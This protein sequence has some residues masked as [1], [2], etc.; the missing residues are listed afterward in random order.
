MSL[1]LSRFLLWRSSAQI[2]AIL[3]I[4]SP[5][6][7]SA[8]T[9]TTV[10]AAQTESGTQGPAVSVVAVQEATFTESVLATGSLVA[11]EEVLVTPQIEGY[12]VHEIFA[13]Q[14]DRVKQGALLAKLA[15]ETLTAQLAQ[16]EASLVRADASI[17]QARSVISQAEASRKQAEAAFVRAQELIKSGATSRSIFDER[18]AAALTADATVTS[19]KD[20]LLVAQAEKVQIEAQ[21]RESKLRLAFTRI[22]APTDGLISRRSA[23]VGALASSIADPMFLI[24]KNGEIE[25]DAEI[26]E[27]Y[28]PRIRVNEPASVEISGLSPRN[29]KVRLISPEIDAATRLGRARIFIGDDPD[30]R[31]GSFARA[32]ID[33]GA[34]TA[35]GVPASAILNRDSGPTV[36]VV[37]DGRIETRTVA[38]GIR[39]GGMVE[40]REGLTA[41]ESVVLKSGMLLRDGDAVR[42]IPFDEKTVSEAR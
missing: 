26:P 34:K 8:Q 31:I 2:A 18:E 32:T 27:I 39:L 14:G 9:V 21:I 13:E 16:L 6:A 3:I 1:C 30:L 42:P 4:A 5:N 24:I 15:D 41:G 11:R 36:Q 7:I 38:V 12:R 25:L 37:K 23:R 20:G 33:T 29:G 35:L 10:E 22:L 17:A 19:A 28:M 40:I